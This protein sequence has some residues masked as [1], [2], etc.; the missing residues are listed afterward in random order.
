[1]LIFRDLAAECERDG[2]PQMAQTLRRTCVRAFSA[3]PDEETVLA[4]AIMA[5][6]DPTARA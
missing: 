6:P 2:N 4:L 5:G 1:M 3:E